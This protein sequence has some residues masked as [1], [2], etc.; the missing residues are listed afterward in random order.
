MPK[1][2]LERKNLTDN[3][4][5]TVTITLTS[6][7]SSQTFCTFSEFWPQVRPSMQLCIITEA[8]VGACKTGQQ[9]TVNVHLAPLANPSGACSRAMA[10]IRA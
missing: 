10:L 8:K 3:P 6:K 1:I 7:F 5:T 4:V 2:Q 9:K